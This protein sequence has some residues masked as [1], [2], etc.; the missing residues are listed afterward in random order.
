MR[1]KQHVAENV[2]IM[3]VS[4]AYTSLLQSVTQELQ[5][6]T[7]IGTEI[8][9]KEGKTDNRTPIYHIQ[10]P[11]KNE[12]IQEVLQGKEVDWKNS[13]AYG[14]SFSDL[15]VLELVGNPVAVRPNHG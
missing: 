8:P 1:L 6:D 12:K 10:G 2:H 9:M 3:L 5:F 14:D 13:F 7:I 4:G 15:P 11:R